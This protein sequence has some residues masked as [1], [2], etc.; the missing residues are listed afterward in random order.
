MH[1]LNIKKRTAFLATV[2]LL[3]CVWSYFMFLRTALSKT[4][5]KKKLHKHLPSTV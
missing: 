5:A 2:I 1:R 3:I 4:D